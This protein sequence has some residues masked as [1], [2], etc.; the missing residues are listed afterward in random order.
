MLKKNILAT[1]I[2]YI[3]LAH[4]KT[5]R[6]FYLKQFD[7]IFKK[8]TKNKHKLKKLIKGPLKQKSLNRIN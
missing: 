1:N 5:Y 6:L 7:K 4:S 8:I 2:I 3:S